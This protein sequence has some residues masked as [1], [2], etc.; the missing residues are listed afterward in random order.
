MVPE[1]D[2]TLLPCFPAGLVAERDRVLQHSHIVS[3]SQLDVRQLVLI[4]HVLR[5]PVGLTLAVY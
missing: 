4:L 2:P 3:I 5:P 1:T